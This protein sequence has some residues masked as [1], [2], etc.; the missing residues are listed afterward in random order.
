[1]QRDL[2]LLDESAQPLPE[3]A[4]GG[5]LVGVPTAV[6]TLCG[7]P[8]DG[9]ADRGGV[10]GPLQRCEVQQGIDRTVSGAHHQS[11]TPAQPLGVEA[12]HVGQ[13]TQQPLGDLSALLTQGG[14]TGGTER[15]RSAPG[16]GGVDDRPRLQ[17]EHLPGMSN[18]HREGLTSPGL[19]VGLVALP[20]ADREHPVIGANP[21]CQLG[22]VGQ[23]L[24]VVIH[25]LGAGGQRCGARRFPTSGVQQ[26]RRGGIDV[27]APGREELD[28]APFADGGAHLRSNLEHQRL[29]PLFEQVRGGGQ[30]GRTGPDDDDGQLSDA[31][32]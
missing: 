6:D 5:Q 3:G 2:A 26:P 28:V 11:V 15:I 9:P 1:M 19:D 24:E 21:A 14:E 17:L 27:V 4:A 10:V 30:S 16:A 18:A 32:R 7:F 20:S 29:Q 22:R 31:G 8:A 23:G 13:R 25:E 12:E